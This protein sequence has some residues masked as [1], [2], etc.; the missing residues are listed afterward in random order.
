MKQLI[1]LVGLILGSVVFMSAPSASAS[2]LNDFTISSYNI[3]Y[4]LGRNSQGASTLNTTETITAD[5]PYSDQNH[6]IERAI[7]ETYDGHSTKLDIISVTN[8]QSSALQYTTYESNGN[9]VV[10]I[11]DADRYVHGAQTYIISY[12]QQYVT[13]IFADT[14]ADEFY[15]DTNGTDWEVPINALSVNLT[16]DSS[17][18]SSLNGKTACYQGMNNATANCELSQMN[19]TFSVTSG[20]MQAGENIT[21]AVGFKPGT[22]TP[23]APSLMERL[24]LIWLGLLLAGLIVA[25]LVVVWAIV[26]WYLRTNRSAE[27]GTIIPEYLPPKDT[28]VTTSATIVHAQTKAFAAQLIDFAVR[29]YIKIYQTSEKSFWRRAEYEIEVIRDINTLL[30][31]EQEILR[32][33]FEDEPVVGTKLALKKLKNNTK[34]FSKMADNTKKLDKLVRGSYGLRAPNPAEKKWFT[35]TSLLL[36]ILAVLTLNPFLLFAAIVVFILGYTLCPLTDSGLALSRYLAGLKEYIRVAEVDRLKM[37]QSPEGAVKVGNVNPNDPAQLVKLYE[38]VLPYAILFGQEKDW[39]A[40]LGRYYESTQA[41]PDWFQGNG[42]LFTAAAFS[43]AIS[44]F[45]TSASYSAPGSSSSGGSSGGGF[46][47]GGG[48]GGGGG[49]W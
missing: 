17:L 11:G 31:E 38:R 34:V 48:G 7:P 12:Q 15:W 21:L 39:N 41:S 10:R 16:V 45:S 28:S 6:G 44:S 22:F 13:D 33:I 40:Q 42:S 29:H 30:P 37:L 36:L 1:A 27:K 4:Q 24:V 8:A 43:G 20:P 35:R 32:D 5:F 25:L 9:T 49:G 19:G 3:A 47:G 46:S 14:Q 2:G 18:M 23:Y 26:R